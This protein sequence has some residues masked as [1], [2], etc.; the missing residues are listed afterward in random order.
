MSQAQIAVRV[1]PRT[2]RD[3]IAGWQDGALHVRLRAP[4]VDGQAN[5]ALRR[6]LAKQLDVS[7]SA[8]EIIG[9][10]TARHKRVRIDGLTVDEVRSRLG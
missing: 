5:E 10:A 9:G 1:T 4:P 2:G 7:P 6:F 8:V 3:E